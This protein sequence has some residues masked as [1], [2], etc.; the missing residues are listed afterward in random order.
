MCL[1][2]E[3][4]VQH[5]LAAWE[6]RL[7]S[8]WVHGV[9]LTVPVE[10]AAT[11]PVEKAIRALEKAAANGR[12]GGDGGRQAAATGWRCN[13]DGGRRAT[14]LGRGGDVVRGH[15]DVVENAEVAWQ[16]AVTTLWNRSV[17]VL[18]AF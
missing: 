10:N 2:H 3:L 18:E 16:S 8:V 4:S 5:L 7:D 6:W 11:S 9:E 1:R 14:A 17:Q 13:G 15:S 12:R